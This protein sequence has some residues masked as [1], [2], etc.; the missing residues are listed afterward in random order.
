MVQ[1]DRR[2]AARTLA[3]N[4]RADSQLTFDLMAADGI[5]VAEYLRR[6]L[7][8]EKV[9]LFGHSQ[10]TIVGVLMAQRRPDLFSA[11]VGTGQITD[12][13][14]N[15]AGSYA[16]AVRR[17]RTADR[18]KAARELA[19]IGAPPYPA[20][21]TWLVKQRWSF[22]TDPELRAWGK[23]SLPMVLF[24]PHRSLRD[25]YLFNQAF[26]CYPQPLYEETMAW[27]AGQHGTR[28]EIPVFLFHGDRDEHTLTSLA[29]EYFAGLQAP[30]RELVLIP[31]GGHCAVLMQPDAFLTLL[32]DR[33]AT[34]ASGAG[35]HLPDEPGCLR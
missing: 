3:R 17:A 16:L 13:A 8:A 18:A 22:D 14:R 6:R 34:L 10:G 20:S 1:W 28:F 31:G 29:T 27:D 12:M 4:G 26:T 2:G 32:R 35:R 21:S 5:E 11:Y 24:A 23:R 7:H 25:V 15:E 19:R 33:V 30:V 9:F